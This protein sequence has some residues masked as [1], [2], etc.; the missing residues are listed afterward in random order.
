M[1]TTPN[2]NSGAP[3]WA[4]LLQETD[5]K[6]E[7]RPE[8]EGWVRFAELKKTLGVSRDKIAVMLRDMTAQGRVET[9][10]GTRLS[11][12]NKRVASVWY[13]IRPAKGA[14]S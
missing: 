14:R 4:A 12:D 2:T 3:D 5:I 10:R 8:G 11:S 7:R 6:R 9:F 1:K 13:R